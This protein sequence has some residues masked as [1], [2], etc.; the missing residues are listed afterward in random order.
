MKNDHDVRPSAGPRGGVLALALLLVGPLFWHSSLCAQQSSEKRG[1]DNLTVV[2]HLPLGGAESMADIE[3][4]QD[5]SRP[6]VYVARQMRREDRRAPG[7]PG[8][9]GLDILD[10]SDPA[11]PE[12]IHRW[13]IEDP[14][15]HVGAGGK[16]IKTFEWDGRHYIV[17]SFQFGQGGPNADLGAIVFD[18]TGLPD[19]STFREVARIQGP[20]ELAG[21]HNAYVYRH[22][23][24]QPLLFATVAAPHANVY[25]LGYLVD[26]RED[27][28]VATVPVPQSEVVPGDRGY[29]DFYVGYHPDS[30]QDR[31]YGGGT[32]G[33]YVYNI[34]DLEAP[35]LLVT[36]TGVRGVDRGH[37]FTPSPDGRYV[38]AEVEYQYAPLRIFDLKPG[39]GGEVSNINQPIVAWFAN[40]QNLVHNHEVRWP[41][42]FV[43]AYRDGLQVFSLQDPKKPRT[44]AHYDTYLEPEGAGVTTG[45]W[46]VDVRNADG[47]IVLS[48]KETG[49][50]AFRL[51]GFNGWNGLDYGMPNVSSVQDWEDG[52]AVQARSRR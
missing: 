49:F 28:L 2:S 35:E 16:D 23:N 52:P 37:T 38:V 44:V 39:L 41:L 48:D 40:P 19:V 5:M 3:I 27:A 45:G 10:I 26:G 47:L 46:G 17:L 8:D 14:D 51:E 33:Y 50:W 11:N 36:L 20:G 7:T 18:I 22:S 34:T 43:S 29:H 15:L 25:D 30:E 4:E 31:F 13:R 24:G 32:G 12:V 42:V 21:F 9:R 1:S 6:F